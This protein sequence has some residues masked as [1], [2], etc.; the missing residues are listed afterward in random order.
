MII[1]FEE[2]PNLQLRIDNFSVP[3]ESRAEFEVSMRRNLAFIET[4]PGFRGHAVVEK[5]SGPTCF[6]FATIAAWESREALDRAGERVRTHYG[7]I[8]FD[9]PAMLARWGVRAELG[10]FR[11]SEQP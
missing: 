3:P 7:E 10:N 6:N 5:T 4:L 8:G 1:D 11:G 9:L 2:N